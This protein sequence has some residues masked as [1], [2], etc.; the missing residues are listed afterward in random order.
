LFTIVGQFLSPF[1]LVRHIVH[2]PLSESDDRTLRQNEDVVV[3]LCVIRGGYR[4]R[5]NQPQVHI[6]ILHYHNI[7]HVIL[8]FQLEL[9]QVIEFS[10]NIIPIQMIKDECKK[11]ADE[12][13]V[14]LVETLTSEMNPQMVCAVSGKPE[15]FNPRMTCFLD[16]NEIFIVRSIVNLCVVILMTFNKVITPL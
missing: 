1:S 14:E 9:K 3:A 5:P 10:C 4:I 7:A 12:F 15:V 8:I 13:V 16:D 2:C 6:Y 11:L